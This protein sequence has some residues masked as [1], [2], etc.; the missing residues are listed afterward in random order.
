VKREEELASGIIYHGDNLDALK[1]IPSDSIKLIYLDP[2]FFTRKNY[3][4]GFKEEGNKH[5]FSDNNWENLQDYIQFIKERVIEL[6]RVLKKDGALYLHCDWHAS[7]YIKIILDNVFGYD[8]FRNEISVKRIKK[9]VNEREMVRKLNV[10]Y[11]VILFYAKSEKHLINSPK[12]DEE[13]PE[14]WHS[15][16][17]PETRKGMDYELFGFRP[18]KG[19]HWRWSKERAMKS[20]KE[21]ILRPNSKTGKP[22]YLIPKSSRTILDNCWDDITAYSFKFGYPTE[23]NEKLL[24]RIIEMS[25]KKGDIVLD[26]FCGCGT[27]I[28]SAF[29]KGRRFIGMDLSLSACEL[30]KKRVG[31]IKIIKDNNLF[32]ERLGMVMV[33]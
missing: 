1:S 13:K 24:D 33:N 5:E 4:K 20:I 10:G 17:A 26:P 22:E 6:Y 18:K 15:F 31:E 12:K 32:S 30:V 16:E 11:D 27:T 23:K 21:G 28:A 29:K 19:N 7:H 9:N 3:S 8:N 25:S 2:P 14:R